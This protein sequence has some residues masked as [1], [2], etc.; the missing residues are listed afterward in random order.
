MSTSITPGT[1]PETARSA[2][3]EDAHTWQ[4]K[5]RAH[6]VLDLVLI[7]LAVIYLVTATGL[8]FRQ[9]GGDPGAG[10]FPILVGVGFLALV[11][12]D[13]VLLVIRG[14]R[15]LWSSGSG[16]MKPKAALLPA[17][18]AFY[19]AVVGVLGHSVTI[20]LVSLALMLAFYRR[21]WWRLALIA[22]AVAVGTDL[23]FTQ[24]LGVRLPLGLLRTEVSSWI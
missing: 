8:T 7:G 10:Y 23:L 12:L 13:A 18:P 15:R 20:A 24:V 4:P 2:E 19:V 11:L 17:A 14:A 3:P 6:L 22:V 9:P 21:P 1:G 16:R 5:E